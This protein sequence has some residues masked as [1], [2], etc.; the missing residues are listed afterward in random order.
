MTI[1]VALNHKTRYE[2]DR[3]VGL[4]PHEV[5]L[6]PASHTRTPIESYSLKVKPAKHFLNW[7][8]DPYGNW[9]ARLVFPDKARE[10]EITVDLVADMTV[11]NP[12]D[13]FVDASAERFPFAYTS[14]NARELA[15][16]LELVPETPRLK[17]WVQKARDRFLGK[18]ITTIDF[19]VAVNHMVR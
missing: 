9:V 4:S 1:K 19:L 10:L 15:P 12:F 3:L 14:E 16:Y 5:R 13:F 11:I 8:Q 7:Q 6:R 17:A 2:Y 18:S